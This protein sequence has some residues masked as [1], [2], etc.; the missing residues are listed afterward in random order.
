MGY[1][2]RKEVKTVSRTEGN[3]DASILVELLLL[4]IE[5]GGSGSTVDVMKPPL[6]RKR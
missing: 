5:G 4:Q 6:T 2:W 3:I 1:A